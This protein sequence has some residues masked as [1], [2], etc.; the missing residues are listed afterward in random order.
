MITSCIDADVV[1]AVDAT[2]HE[3]AVLALAGEA[4]LEDHHR[5]DDLGALEVGD[6]VAL[7]PQR[8]LVEAQRLLD[9]LERLVARR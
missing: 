7:D 3:P 6:V 2:D 4:V 9:L 1:L 5:R 8:R